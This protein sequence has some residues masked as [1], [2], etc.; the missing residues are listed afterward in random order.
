MKGILIIMDQLRGK[1][2]KKKLQIGQLFPTEIT[3]LHVLHHK[4]YQKNIL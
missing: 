4:K 2:T 3:Q 1:K